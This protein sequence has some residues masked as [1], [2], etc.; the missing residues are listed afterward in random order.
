MPEARTASPVFEPP[1][2]TT[3]SGPFDVV[4]RRAEL[5]A[6]TRGVEATGGVAG[7]DGGRTAVSADVAQP[8]AS[9][10]S[11]MA[12]S[13]QAEGPRDRSAGLERRSSRRRRGLLGRAV[14][15]AGITA[16][17][18]FES[19]PIEVDITGRG[20]RA[21]RLQLPRQP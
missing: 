1:S 20:V 11:A 18:M 16:G 7:G 9:G 10:P 17:S 2:S 5:D 15:A 21:P 3:S 13:A 4:A 19:A 12:T 8:A 14:P 6:A